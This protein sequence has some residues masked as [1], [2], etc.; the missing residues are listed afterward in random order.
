MWI[1][2]FQPRSSFCAI[3]FPYSGLT[4]RWKPHS[5]IF[6]V[7]PLRM[8]AS[9]GKIQQY[10]S[11]RRFQSSPQQP[12][13]PR[14]LGV[15]D[16]ASNEGLETVGGT[17]SPMPSAP[18]KDSVPR[19]A[20]SADGAHGWRSRVPTPRTCTH[21]VAGRA[22]VLSASWAAIHHLTFTLDLCFPNFTTKL[23]EKTI[24]CKLDILVE[25]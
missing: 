25:A 9:L 14:S 5:F 16:C 15:L 1:H 13:F 10:V 8:K 2:S 12:V 20:G 22:W 19:E 24:S 23:Q 18:L 11:P 6:H 3:T 7:D 4:L 21:R 17:G